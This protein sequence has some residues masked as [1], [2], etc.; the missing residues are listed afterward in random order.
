[1]GLSVSTF[2]ATWKSDQGQDLTEL[3][4]AVKIDNLLAFK[5]LSDEEIVELSQVKTLKGGVAAQNV[6]R[7]YYLSKLAL[8]VIA[9]NPRYKYV[10]HTRTDIDLDLGRYLETWFEPDLYC[11]VHLHHFIN[12]QFAIAPTRI[13]QAAWNYGSLSELTRLME[14]AA[15]PEDI[16]QLMIDNAGIKPVRRELLYITLDPNRK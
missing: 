3:L 5:S 6:F 7:Q 10:I 16:L 12:D 2:L 11:T 9:A 8:D 4:N 1:M 15:I 14:Q 13:M